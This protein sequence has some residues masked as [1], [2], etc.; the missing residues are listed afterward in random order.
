[1]AHPRRP[2][3]GLRSTDQ[4]VHT[5][6]VV[7]GSGAAGLTTALALAGSPVV[8]L[9]KSQLGQGGSSPLAQGGI[10]AAMG[11]DDSPERHAADTLAV[12]G[13]LSDPSA[14]RL[15]TRAAPEQIRFLLRLGAELDRTPERAL[16]LNREAGHSR[17]RIVH[18]RDRTGAELVR[19]LT[20]AVR[21]AGVG[22]A[23]RTFAVDVLT[24]DGKVAGL[25]ARGP[26]G[27]RIVYRCGAVVL[28]TGGIGRLYSH[29]TNPSEVTG[30]GLAMAARAGARLVDLEFMQFHPTAL[31][32][33]RD[34]MPLLTEALRGEGALLVDDTGRRL[35]HGLHPAGELA[36]RDVVAR[37]IW[38]SLARGRRTLLDARDAIGASFPERFP[39]VFELCQR[40]GLD[41]R[42]QPIPVAPAA[43]FH[44]GGIAVDA[45]GRASVP[46]LW[47]VGEDACTGAHGA[48]R[49]ASNS[50][51]E[52][53]VFAG[54]VAHDVRRYGDGRCRQLSPMPNVPPA[55]DLP[56]EDPQD[57]TS[58]LR[59]LM[60]DRVGLV[61]DQTGLTA[62]IDGIELLTRRLGPCAVEARNM[63]E[64]ARLV[65]LAALWRR[66]SRGAHYRHDHPTAA[67]GRP[68]RLTVVDQQLQQLWER[69][70]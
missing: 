57:I 56:R 58:A 51:L 59:S 24:D 28:A 52:A 41:P 8:L 42:V 4:V 47:A 34:P 12:G 54:R 45:V 11:H 19:T 38:Q 17:R 35:M 44:M 43:H 27:Q 66:E 48:N 39:N 16:S 70:A 26:E 62:A 36:P 63:L 5:G 40:D 2:S 1:M 60:W 69:V 61:R 20:A 15:L 64:V 29:T 25:L 10:A 13:G 67:A 33:G 31:A 46:G 14:V 49:L 9:T 23:E 7:V 53:V 3:S 6:A 18:A 21:A 50:L 65:A 22:V 30:D 32:S 68:V 37:G 55:A